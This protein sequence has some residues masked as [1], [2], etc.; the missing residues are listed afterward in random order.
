MYEQWRRLAAELDLPV[1]F[2]VGENGTPYSTLLQSAYATITT[3]VAEGFGLAFLEPWGV[4][5][6]LVGRNLPDITADFTDEGIRLDGLYTRLDVPKDWVDRQA[7]NRKI[8]AGVKAARSAYGLPCPAADVERAQKAAVGPDGIDFARL[9][10]EL[11]S[12]VIRRAAETEEPEP[13]GASP[14]LLSVAETQ[15]RSGQVADNAERVSHAYSLTRYGERLHDIYQAL[16]SAPGAGTRDGL[17]P[18]SLLRVFADPARFYLL[19]TS[20]PEGAVS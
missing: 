19:R 14:D 5:L 16:L 6:P 13:H 7:L 4:G 9:D 17:D 11:Q 18:E 12:A 20:L 10:E 3:S 15:A 1:A 8:E 2:A